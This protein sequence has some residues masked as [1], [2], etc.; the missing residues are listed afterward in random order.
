M[1]R[2]SFSSVFIYTRFRVCPWRQRDYSRKRLSRWEKGLLFFLYHE[3]NGGDCSG[4]EKN[5]V[6]G[7]IVGAYE[8]AKLAANFDPQKP[9]L[10]HRLL[11]RKLNELMKKFSKAQR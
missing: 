8:N 4:I 7:T 5:R 1:A 2:W 10:K 9:R 3:A 11:H 6:L